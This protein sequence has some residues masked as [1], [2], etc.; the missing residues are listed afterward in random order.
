LGANAPSGEAASSLT[1][2]QFAAALGASVPTGSSA[3]SGSANFV[4]GE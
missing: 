3:V 1:Y 2:A 4:V